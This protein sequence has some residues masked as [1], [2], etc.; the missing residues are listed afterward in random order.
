MRDPGLSQVSGETIARSSLKE[1]RDHLTYYILLCVQR[2]TFATCETSTIICCSS[3]RPLS[4]SEEGGIGSIL[5]PLHLWT[6]G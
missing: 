2:Q 1:L 4:A 5:V 6:P 3:I